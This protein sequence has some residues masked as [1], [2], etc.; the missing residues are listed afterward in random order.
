MM[1]M[2]ILLEELIKI[3][4]N[5]Q[6]FIVNYGKGYFSDKDVKELAYWDEEIKAYR[7]ETGIWSMELL[8]QIAKG[9]VKNT[10]IEI[11]E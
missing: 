6:D 1:D 4:N 8:Y 5:K 10:S 9:E 2:K 7:G 3:I 11:G